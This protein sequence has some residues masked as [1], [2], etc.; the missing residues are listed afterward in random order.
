M[1][2]M[3]LWGGFLALT[4]GSLAQAEDW[5]PTPLS[6][7]LDPA[8]LQ[9]PA[10]GVGAQVVRGQQEERDTLVTDRP[11]FT[12]ASST[13]GYGR[14]QLE[15]GYTFAYDDEDG[16]ITRTHGLPETLFRIG[17]TDAIE[18]R[19]FWNY[20]W[21]ET[22]DATGTVAD[23]GAEDFGIGFKLFLL[24]EQGLAPETAVIVG[25]TTPTGGRSFTSHK[26]DAGVN[27]LYS[28]SLPADWSIA[29]SSGYATGSEATLLAPELLAVDQHGVF[30][31]SVALGI[32]LN[33]TFGCYL[34]YFGFYFHGS[35]TSGPQHF[36]NGGF[37]MLAND[38]VQLDW[39][40]GMGLNQAADDFFTGVGYSQRF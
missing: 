29:G 25:M 32:P 15:M 1:L 30:T 38:D 36:L 40:V 33:E 5:R 31:Q 27:L 14:V 9:P 37:T 28:W 13:V 35:D 22:S 23:D 21:Q 7:F 2:R 16:T 19:L 10:D 26:V 34:E 6:E 17:L 12:E 24:E 8:S 20:L 18:L 39:R 11:D 3:L 4:C